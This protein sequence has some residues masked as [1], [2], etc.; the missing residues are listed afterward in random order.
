MTARLRLPPGGRSALHRTMTMEAKTIARRF[1]SRASLRFRT[2]YCRRVTIFAEVEADH[3]QF[4][5]AASDADTSWAQSDDE[6]VADSPN[7]VVIRTGISTGPVAV[8][9]VQLRAE[10]AG[11]AD[12]WETVGRA[13]VEVDQPLMVM[14]TFGDASEHHDVVP[15]PETGWLAVRVSATGRSAQSD[16]IV[17]ES[18]E[19]YLI[20]VWSTEAPAGSGLQRNRERRNEGSAMDA[21]AR[22]RGPVAWNPET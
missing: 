17:S 16:A 20:E 9:L 8:A 19:R 22:L 1:N 15:P 13:V 7:A 2:C 10:P 3:Q 21:T 11:H 6:M 5:L 18:S 12:Q 4:F 14:T